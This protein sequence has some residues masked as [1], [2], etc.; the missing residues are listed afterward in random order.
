MEAQKRG[1][2][3][4]FLQQINNPEH[5]KKMEGLRG[6]IVTNEMASA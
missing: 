4:E 3:K 2:R 1:R 6:K 5:I